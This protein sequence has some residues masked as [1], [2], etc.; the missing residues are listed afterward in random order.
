MVTAW[1]PALDCV[2]EHE[3][4][5]DFTECSNEDC[6]SR[7]KIT[8]CYLSE[9]ARAGELPVLSFRLGEVGAVLYVPLSDLIVNDRPSGRPRV[10]VNPSDSY[11]M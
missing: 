7:K 1:I 8:V 10:C 2:Q 5:F 3:E 9:G 6:S 4:A 11:A